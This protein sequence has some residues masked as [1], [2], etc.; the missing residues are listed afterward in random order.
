M[1][2]VKECR[3]I[4]ALQSIPEFKKIN[5]SGDYIFNNKGKLEKIY[6]S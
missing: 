5:I 2:Y 4:S 6:K 3:W 1:I